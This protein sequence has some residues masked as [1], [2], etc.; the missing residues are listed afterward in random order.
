[1]ASLTCSARSVARKMETW[2][3]LL[4]SVTMI[5]LRGLVV[6][7]KM[8]RKVFFTL[9]LKVLLRLVELVRLMMIMARLMCSGEGRLMLPGGRRLD[10]LSAAR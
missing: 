9:L 1:M 6:K 8:V 2:E 3:Q 7:V 5:R 10:T 4:W